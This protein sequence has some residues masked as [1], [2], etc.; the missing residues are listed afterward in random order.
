MCLLQLSS[1][2]H[3]HD[4]WW[5]HH[6]RL[7]LFIL[8]LAFYQTDRV[9]WLNSSSTC[10]YRDICP[11]LITKTSLFAATLNTLELKHL[12]FLLYLTSLITCAQ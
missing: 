11:Y 12:L 6:P 10:S 8:P 9:Y 4:T 5:W 7:S 2:W 1:D 3:E